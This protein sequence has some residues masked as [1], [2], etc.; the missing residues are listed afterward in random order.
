[1][2]FVSIELLQF[3]LDKFYLDMI[4]VLIWATKNMSKRFTV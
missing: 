2:E 3:S 4:F 1:M